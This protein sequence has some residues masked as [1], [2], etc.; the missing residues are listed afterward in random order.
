MSK[1]VLVEVSARHVHVSEKDLETLFGKG[2]QLHPR[3]GICLPTRA[4]APKSAVPS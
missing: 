1:P 2:Y 4:V 3:K